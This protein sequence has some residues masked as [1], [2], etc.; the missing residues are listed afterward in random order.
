MKWQPV[1]QIEIGIQSGCCVRQ[2]KIAGDPGYQ[3]RRR[4]HIRKVRDP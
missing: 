1:S 4:S 2:T 3:V